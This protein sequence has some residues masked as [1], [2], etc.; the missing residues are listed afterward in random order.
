MSKE[1]KGPGTVEAATEAN[2]ITG[3][4]GTIKFDNPIRQR[5]YELFL[6]GQQFSVVQLS[7]MLRVP[8]V[9]SHIRYIRDS[10]VPI[11]DYW[12]KSRFSKYKVYFLHSDGGQ[13]ER[14]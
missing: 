4:K 12:Q 5:I 11:C 6:S 13:N 1:E 7:V 2:E 14:I 10:G 3:Y 8:D 9:R